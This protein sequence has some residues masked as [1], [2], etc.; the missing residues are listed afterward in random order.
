MSA[1][2]FSHHQPHDVLVGGNKGGP[3]G[4]ARQLLEMNELQHKTKHYSI[5][6]ELA[7]FRFRVDK[8]YCKLFTGRQILL[9][10]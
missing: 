3:A 9:N 6:R 2:S 8:C 5:I 1:V 10:R 4:P 7:E